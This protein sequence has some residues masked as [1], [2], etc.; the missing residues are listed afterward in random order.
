VAEP[1][2]PD[3]GSSGPVACDS[4][5]RVEADASVGSFVDAVE[6]EPPPRP[7]PPLLREREEA[8]R[9]AEGLSPSGEDRGASGFSAIVSVDVADGLAALAARVRRAGLGSADG[10]GGWAVADLGSA[11]GFAV[12]VSALGIGAPR[13]N[14]AARSAAAVSVAGALGAAMSVSWSM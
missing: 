2:A 8:G 6:P 12:L 4:A 3:V 5:S 7:R 13:L 11:T 9:S 1:E 14:A 10:S